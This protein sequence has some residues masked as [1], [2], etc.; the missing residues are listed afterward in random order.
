M[1]AHARAQEKLYPT[2]NILKPIS[3]Y[4]LEQPRREEPA[5]LEKLNVDRPGEKI[6]ILNVENDRSSRGGFSLYVPEY[7]ENSK[8]TALVMALHGDTGHGRDFLWFWLREARSR[9][10]MLLAPTS[11]H[12][13]WSLMSENLDLPV[14]LGLVEFIARDFNLDREHILLTGMSDGGTYTLLAGLQHES[15]FTHL[16]SFSG[17]LHPDISLNG[18]IKH[19]QDRDIYLVHGTYD[20]MFPIETAHMAKAELEAAG[21]KLTFREIDGLSHTYARTENPAVLDWF[22]S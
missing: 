17:V 5:L 6:G 20:W 11:Q 16:A 9:G 3:Q 12:D 4:F 10:F 19:A 8:P 15:P 18:N 21:A 7:L 2:A 14:L 1:R 22:L 13:T